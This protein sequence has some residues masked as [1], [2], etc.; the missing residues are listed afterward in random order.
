MTYRVGILSTHPIQYYSPW[1]RGLAAHPELDLTVYYAHRSTAEDQASAGFGVKFE[2]DLPLLEGYPHEF[3]INRARRPSLSGFWGCHTP[4]ILA[5]LQ[6]QRFDAFIVHGWYNRSYW[7][8]IRGCWATRTPVMVRGDSTLNMA[9]GGWRKLLKGITHRFFVPRFDAYLVVGQR[10]REYYLAFGA[11]PERMTF[12]PHF[13]E[14]DRFTRAADEARPRR[15]ELRQRWGLP[16]DAIVYLFA[17]KFIPKKRPHDFVQGVLQ[18]S[19]LAPRVAGLMVGDGPL[20]P[21]VEQLVQQTKAPVRFTGF[22]NQTEIPA[23]YAVCDALVLPSDGEETWGLV[24]NEAMACGLPC[25]VSDQVGCAPD[26]VLEES[27]GQVFP[28]MDVPALAERLA[29]L[30]QHPELLQRMGSQ[31]REHIQRYSVDNAVT[32]TFQAIARW[33]RKPKRGAG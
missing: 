25:L 24:V 28:F 6:R 32:G 30:G 1:Y 20:R 13:V 12:V 26:L 33:S 9:R 3:L 10:A 11:S 17:A 21:E 18:A 22:L 14:N 19:R 16:E 15:G 7:Q 27:T 31:A 29:R 8:A 2:W 4:E 23:A 5:I